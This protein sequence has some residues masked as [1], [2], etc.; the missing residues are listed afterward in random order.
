M[1][2]PP[3]ARPLLPHPTKAN[4]PSP[5]QQGVGWLTRKII[6]MSTITLT[7][8]EYID[9]RKHTHI[10]IAQTVTGGISG[11]T[12]KRTL[13]WQL[14]THKDGIFGECK[15]R[16]RWIKVEDLEEGPD[17]EWLSK[18]WLD[19]DGGDHVQSWVENE[20][21]GWTAEQVS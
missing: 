1:V 8:N 13:D 7:I 3:S 16:S 17:K 15:G 21:N 5:L 4:L 18:G 19:E 2:P 20:V 10:D 12:E 6:R 14:R 9:D 11:T